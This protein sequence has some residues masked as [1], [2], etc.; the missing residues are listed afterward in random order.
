MEKYFKPLFL[1]PYLDNYTLYKYTHLHV[2][3]HLNVFGYWHTI[4]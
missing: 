4:H 2:Y 3:I 1:I